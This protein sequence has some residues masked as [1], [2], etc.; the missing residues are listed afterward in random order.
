MERPNVLLIHTDQQRWDALGAN[1]NQEIHTP[2]LDRLAQEGVNFD[3]YFVQ[4][5]VCM[6]SRLSYLTG[7]YPST[8]GV[9][10]NGVPVPEDTLALPGLLDNYGYISANIGKLHF[11]PHA[12]RDHRDPHPKYGFD[13]LEISD[14]PG[15]YADAYRAWVK[16]KDPTRLDD[17]SVGLPPAAA[18]W[19]QVMGTEDGINH[20][21][22]R[23][24]KRPVSFEGGREFTHSAFVAERTID[25]IEGHAND[26]FLCIAGFYSP[27]SPWVAPEEFFDLYDR[28][29]LSLP[30]FPERLEEKRGEDFFSDQEL[31]GAKQGYYG[32]VSE[33]DG[34]V[35]RILERLEELGLREN[36]IVVFTSDHGEYLGDHL[37]YGKGSPGYDP[38]SRVPLIFSSPDDSIDDGRTF[39][40]IVEAVDLV[41]TLLDC[42]GVPLAP[43]LGGESLLP[44]LSGKKKGSD[45]VALTESEGA[46]SIRTKRF[47]YVIREDGEESLFD[48]VQD[49]GEYHNLVED[50][51]KEKK[52]SELRKR[53]L[54]K[55]I[56]VE[57]IRPRSWAY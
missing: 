23:F 4:N 20:P 7:Q 30:N 19:Q 18:R 52:L 16:K 1:G 44:L 2:N 35:G 5:P 24:P 47:R 57:R 38:I 49:P 42:V 56:K 8:H 3:H 36:T 33:V 10:R 11:L 43:H 28:E 55:V 45:K 27:H 48:L 29:K 53:A 14:E 6:P 40:G 26:R 22:E 12:N 54:E 50:E 17:I 13:H 41:P 34:H 25:F 46:K 32:M 9:Y 15:P 37:S 39:E 31:L 21:A 51:S